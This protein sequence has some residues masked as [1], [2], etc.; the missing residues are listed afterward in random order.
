MQRESDGAATLSLVGM[1]RCAV[2]VAACLAVASERRRKRSLRRRNESSESH[3]FGQREERLNKRARFANSI[4]PPDAAL[5]G[6]D[7][8]LRRPYLRFA[9]LTSLK[10]CLFLVHAH[11]G[12]EDCR[13]AK[14]ANHAGR[15]VSLHHGETAD[16]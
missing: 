7:G 16:V 4:A 15:V 10:N 3:G 8:A 14:V 9:Q 2:T 12:R 5:G 1:A 13:A 11:A 6:A